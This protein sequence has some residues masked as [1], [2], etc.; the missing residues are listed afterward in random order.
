MPCVLFL[1][2]GKAEAQWT[3]LGLPGQSITSI[4]II[5]GDSLLLLAGTLYYPDEPER[6]GIFR[7]RDNGITWD[8]VA[9]PY[10]WVL[11]I[12]TTPL[13]PGTVLAAT[14]VG[15]LRSR[16]TGL[17]WDTVTTAGT[18]CPGC[19][20]LALA[21]NPHDSLDWF[22]GTGSPV[23]GEGLIY[24][25]RDGGETWADFWYDLATQGLIFSSCQNEILYGAN[26]Y[27]VFRYDIQDS[28]RELLRFAFWGN[29][30]IAVH[31]RKPYLYVGT[32]DT[33]LRFHETDSVWTNF[34]IGV[35]HDSYDLLYTGLQQDGW[36]FGTSEGVYLVDSTFASAELLDEGTSPGGGSPKAISSRGD[37]YAVFSGGIHLWHL[38][39]D[40]DDHRNTQ[41][42]PPTPIVFP[43]P[44]KSIIY[45][46]FDGAAEIRV[47]N[48]IGQLVWSQ[49]RRGQG[50]HKVSFQVN[51][52]PNG[53]YYYTIHCFENNPP[54]YRSG[55]FRVIH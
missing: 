13:L 2:L 29:S 28:T 24:R 37:V 14:S 30:D 52:L 50:L 48:I 46:W 25:S 4:A 12:L 7:S 43:N 41:P 9:L 44:A 3:Y 5:E 53:P 15:L 31:P 45:W 35:P 38:V 20:Q 21:I 17:T 47:Y 51:N 55:S 16:D 26:N 33:L 42:L 32:R 39:S 6:G 40:A 10:Q 11:Q 1:L 49:D 18:W 19:M 22:L 23:E 8:R 27:G 34:M 36:I 54:A